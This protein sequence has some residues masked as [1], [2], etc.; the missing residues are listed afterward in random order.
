MNVRR[1]IVFKVEACESRV[2]MSSTENWGPTALLVNQDD[3]TSVFPT[4]TGAGVSVAVI[5]SG[6][7]YNLDALGGGFGRGRKVIGGYDF[8]DHD[9]DPIDTDGHGTEVA[10]VI[11]SKPFDLNG[12]HYA[13]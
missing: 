11:A 1:N 13:G 9:S 12:F 2:L 6:I 7:N 8:V 5:D 4:I 10:G 3:A